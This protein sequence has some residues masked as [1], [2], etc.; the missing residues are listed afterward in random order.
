MFF[1]HPTGITGLRGT[2][3]ASRNA[4]GSCRKFKMFPLAV[5]HAAFDFSERPLI[6]V[7]SDL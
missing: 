1:N 2:L 3:L 5:P 6:D 7:D 4:S